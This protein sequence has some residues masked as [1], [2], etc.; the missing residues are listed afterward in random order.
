MN[1]QPNKENDNGIGKSEI[2]ILGKRIIGEQQQN[3]HKQ[4]YIKKKAVT[5]KINYEAQKN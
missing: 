2:S 5:K 4:I 3:V 1:T